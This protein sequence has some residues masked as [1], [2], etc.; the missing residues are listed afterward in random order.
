MEIAL[1][2]FLPFAIPLISIIMG[3]GIAMLALWLDHQKKTHIFELHHKERMLAIERGLDVPPLP[4]ELFQN[5]RS[6]AYSADAKLALGLTLVLV[7]LAVGVAL[8][9]NFG[10]DVATW[11]LIPLAIGA[12]QLAVYAFSSKA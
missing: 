2:H 12:A 4:P 7:G 10:W 6:P 3:I 11:A 9:V 1:K 5:T 8:T